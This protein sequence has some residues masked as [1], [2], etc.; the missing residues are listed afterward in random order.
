MDAAKVLLVEDD[1][2]L[3]QILSEYLTLKGLQTRLARDGEEGW[4][5]FQDGTYDLCILDLMMPKKD[6]FALASDIRTRDETVPIIFLTA[7]SLKEDVIQGFKV[8][9]DDYVTKPFSMEELLL[10]INAVLKRTLKD[11]QSS[12]FPDIFEIGSFRYHY[13]ENKLVTSLREIKLTTKENELMKIFFEN[14]NQTVD[15]SHALKRI[16]KDDSYFNARSMDVYIAKLRKYLK[17]DE[18]IKIL[19]VH[20]EGF[21]LVHLPT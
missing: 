18:Q 21:K 11:T 4:Q 6:G 16:W 15:R 2:N 13:H 19:T 14:V 8:G 20:G 1:P 5:A 10:R 12:S 3:G 17:D 9:G 7:K